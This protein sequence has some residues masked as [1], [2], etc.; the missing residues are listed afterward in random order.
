MVM[1]FSNYL[2]SSET[3][4]RQP[5]PFPK[6]DFFPF[7]TTTV[8]AQSKVEADR[9]N[10]SYIKEKEKGKLLKGPFIIKPNDGTSFAELHREIVPNQ[11][12]LNV[13]S[14]PQTQSGGISLSYAFCEQFRT[15]CGPTPSLK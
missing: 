4:M 8:M 2:V 3:N 14:I 12:T 1:L 10:N 13:K 11:K 9:D 6:E 5:V 15:Y 7:T